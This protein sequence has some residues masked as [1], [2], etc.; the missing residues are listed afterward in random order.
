M[1]KHHWLNVKDI[2]W[3]GCCFKKQ[4]QQQKKYK[5]T[6]S[7][8][9]VAPVYRDL[10][11]DSTCD[12]RIQFIPISSL[13]NNWMHTIQNTLLELRTGNVSI[14]LKHTFWLRHTGSL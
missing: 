9:Q 14:T 13:S 10:L 2:Y 5:F 3:V 1:A 6:F 7:S 12:T 4:Q 8:F 11:S